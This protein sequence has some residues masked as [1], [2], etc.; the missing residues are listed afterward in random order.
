MFLFKYSSTSYLINWCRRTSPSSWPHTQG[1][2]SPRRKQRWR[3]WWQRLHETFHPE[4]KSGDESEIG[5]RAG[6]HGRGRWQPTWTW[7]WKQYSI[8]ER[9]SSTTFDGRY[10]RGRHAL[11]GATMDM[12]RCVWISRPRI[13]NGGFYPGSLL[14]GGGDQDLLPFYDW[15]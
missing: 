7:P 12:S 3:W 13:S 9:R 15:R 6:L 11:H 2:S 10:Q 4:Q 8:L 14:P 1:I 5:R